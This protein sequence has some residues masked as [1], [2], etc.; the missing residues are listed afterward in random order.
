MDYQIILL[1]SNRHME[2]R[3]FGRELTNLAEQEQLRAK[4]NYSFLHNDKLRENK[5]TLSARNRNL[6]MPSTKHQEQKTT[7]TDPQM[8]PEYF[9]ENLC[10]LRSQETKNPT[11]GNYISDHKSVS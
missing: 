10:Y 2:H 7:S 8:V 9:E 3:I 1:S 6:V 11:F 5:A 4:R